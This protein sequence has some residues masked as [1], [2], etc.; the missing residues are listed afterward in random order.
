[1]LCFYHTQLETISGKSQLSVEIC[2]RGLRAAGGVSRLLFISLFK[3][4]R[5]TQKIISDP[6]DIL[7]INRRQLR[8]L[9]SLFHNITA[10]ISKDSDFI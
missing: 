10:L 8:S 9:K 5:F 3:F 7:N 2:L 6:C 1:M 4:I